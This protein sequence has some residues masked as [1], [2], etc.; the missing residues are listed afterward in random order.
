MPGHIPSQ[1]PPPSAELLAH[2]LTPVYMV[3]KIYSLKPYVVGMKFR[4]FYPRY[5]AETPEEMKTIA[6]EFAKS[7]KRSTETYNPET[8]VISSEKNYSHLKDYLTTLSERDLENPHIRYFVE[9]NPRWQ[10]VSW[11]TIHACTACSLLLYA[12]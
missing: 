4:H 1:L 5:D 12:G 3:S 6:D 7:V 2:P 10:Q 9:N 8:H 11:L